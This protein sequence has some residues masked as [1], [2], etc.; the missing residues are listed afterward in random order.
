[1]AGTL[2]VPPAMLKDI[3]DWVFSV[4]LESRKE[5]LLKQPTLDGNDVRDLEDA[6]LVL[7]R[8]EGDIL[9]AL[10][11]KKP[12]ATWS[13]YQTMLKY[14]GRFK[15]AQ[16]PPLSY[17]E[18][19]AYFNDFSL[20]DHVDADVFLAESSLKSLLAKETRLQRNMNLQLDRIK[21]GVVVPA[22][23]ALTTQAIKRF[24][25]DPTG[26]VYPKFHDLKRFVPQWNAK[27]RQLLGPLADI[28]K[29]EGEDGV[30]RTVDEAVEHAANQWGEITV[31]VVP[32][33]RSGGSW[34]PETRTLV[35]ALPESVP[36]A[37][38]FM[39]PITKVRSD[40]EDVVRHELQHMVQTYLSMAIHGL[41]SAGSR[42]VGLGFPT[43]KQQTPLYRQELAPDRLSDGSPLWSDRGK[44]LRSLLE[45]GLLNPEEVSLHA[46]DDA[47]F[48]T[49]MEDSKHSLRLLLKALDD[50]DPKRVFRIFTALAP[51][52]KDYMDPYSR[53]SVDHFMYTLSKVPKAREKYR[54]A[55]TE[56]ARVV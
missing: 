39:F 49:R 54:R 53:V 15:I 6:P 8:L 56:L 19:T 44:A 22:P 25:F 12:R 13:A 35:V 46:L 32:N 38:E 11:K 4:A 7:K 20:R 2:Q 34:N 16:P 37:P 31:Q 17:K 52:V 27:Y 40:I 36:R 33:Y 42:P 10:L 28:M 26:W 51:V 55:L 5:F 43:R 50:L 45:Q 3:S 30:A 14:I 41:G 29:V 48:H 18:F 21:S 47:E 23:S 9:Q 1:M 24:P